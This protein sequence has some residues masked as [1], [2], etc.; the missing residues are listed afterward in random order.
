MDLEL[1]ELL[2]LLIAL[3]SG[4]GIGKLLEKR[5]ASADETMKFLQTEIAQS[6]Q[7]W[8]ADLKDLIETHHREAMAELVAIR[9]AVGRGNRLI[10]TGK[11]R[12]GE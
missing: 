7:Q 4:L 11:H 8:R 6:N 10:E 5:Q 3:F 9:K 1:K 2:N 12:Q